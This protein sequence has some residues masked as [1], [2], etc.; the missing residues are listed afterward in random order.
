MK[1][2]V[3]TKIGDILIIYTNIREVANKFQLKVSKILLH[4]FHIL[5]IWDYDLG[6]ET[7]VPHMPQK[8]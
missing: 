7:V 4:T 6:L 2:F 5:D 1:Q 8:I 3:Y